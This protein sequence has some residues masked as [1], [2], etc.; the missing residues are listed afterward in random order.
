M[1]GESEFSLHTD[2][3]S[4]LFQ[5]ARL[6]I[7]QEA[8]KASSEQEI[9]NLWSQLETMRTSRQELGGTRSFSMLLSEVW[10]KENA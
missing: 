7:E 8:Q 10:L 3:G 4:V 2:C 1:Y 5:V 9:S 6:L